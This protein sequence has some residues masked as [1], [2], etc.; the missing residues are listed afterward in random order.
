[1][2][3]AFWGALRAFGALGRFAGFWGFG[4]WIFE[5]GAL[6]VNPFANKCSLNKPL[7]EK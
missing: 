4:I 6:S 3:L 7:Q 5:L 1:M 2:F